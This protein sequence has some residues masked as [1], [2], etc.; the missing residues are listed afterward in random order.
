VCSSNVCIDAHG[1]SGKLDLFSQRFKSRILEMA[2]DRDASVGARAIAV[3][4]QL[5]QCG[6]VLEHDDTLRLYRLTTDRRAKVRHA[7]AKFANQ[8]FLE[9][10]VPE[11]IDPEG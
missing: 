5:A 2:H 6:D 11:N 3:C 10:I 8:Y 9:F 7:A 1:D 4:H